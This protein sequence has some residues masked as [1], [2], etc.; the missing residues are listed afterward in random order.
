MT[1]CCILYHAGF[2]AHIMNVCW[3]AGMTQK[4]PGTLRKQSDS[5]EP[6]NPV[7]C[8]LQNERQTSR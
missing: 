2:P 4:G 1:Q 7:S 6:K 8:R 3:K 5:T